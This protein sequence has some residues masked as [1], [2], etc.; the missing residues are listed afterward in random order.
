MNSDRSWKRC[1]VARYLIVGIL[2]TVVG[3]G[4]IYLG[5]YL[6]LANTVANLVGYAVGIALS[7]T[8]NKRWTFTD[9]GRAPSQ[10]PRFLLVTA[11]AYLV[12]LAT[13]LCFINALVDPHLAQAAGVVPYTVIGYFGSRLFVFRGAVR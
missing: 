3:L 9:K 2:N 6:G 13:V 11:V 8:L 4:I 12:N 7:F 1:S 10:F 5:M